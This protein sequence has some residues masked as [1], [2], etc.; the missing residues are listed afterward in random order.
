MC[1]IPWGVNLLLHADKSNFSCCD[2]LLLN[3]LDLAKYT[4]PPGLS[5]VRPDLLLRWRAICA[6]LLGG[7]PTRM[8][9]GHWSG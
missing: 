7:M 1:R 6:W 9:L 8:S 3:I 5:G 2:V 4:D